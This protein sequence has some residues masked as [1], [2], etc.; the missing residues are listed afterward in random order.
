MAGLSF[1]YAAYST[2]TA[3][4]TDT[5]TASKWNELLSYT[6]PP[7][8][9]MAFSGTTCP[10]NWTEYLPA[11]GRFLRG[12]DNGAGNDPDGTRMPGAVQADAFQGHRHKSYRVNGWTSGTMYLGVTDTPSGATEYDTSFEPI[13]DGV[14][15]TPRTAAETRPKNVAVLFCIK[16]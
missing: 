3:N 15:G 10:T 14:N 9:I 2:L 12:I 7:G 16:Q 6:V 5:L 8:A 1:G 11:R 13:S 4:P